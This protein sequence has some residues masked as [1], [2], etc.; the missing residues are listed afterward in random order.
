M[1]KV[2][3][4]LLFFKVASDIIA[5]VFIVGVDDDVFVALK[6]ARQLPS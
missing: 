5:S 2:E 3:R 6:T 1:Q 4:T